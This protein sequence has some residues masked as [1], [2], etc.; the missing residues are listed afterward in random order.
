MKILSYL[1]NI[2]V[3]SVLAEDCQLRETVLESGTRIIFDSKGAFIGYVAES[4]VTDTRE[5]LKD[6]N[7]I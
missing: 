5:W 4:N 3:E 1:R 6:M 7:K 2:F